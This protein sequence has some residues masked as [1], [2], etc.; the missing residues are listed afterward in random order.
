VHNG[1]T[2]EL[3]EICCPIIAQGKVLGVIGLVAF[4]KTQRLLLLER[5][6]QL[7]DFVHRMAELLASKA[8]ESETLP[9]S[10]RLS[11]P[12]ITAFWPLIIGARSSIA[13]KLEQI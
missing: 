12:L 7:V 2:A 3:A 1:K 8:V 6:D 13:I 9:S 5:K 4:N 10:E 11:S